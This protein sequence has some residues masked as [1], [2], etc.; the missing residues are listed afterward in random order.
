MEWLNDHRFSRLRAAAEPAPLRAEL[1]SV[2]QL[3][4]HAVKLA[5]AHR[6]ATGR[7]ADRLIPR[8]DENAAILIEAHA[9]VAS[10]VA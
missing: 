9:L 2:D 4:R 6:L 10:A 5:G 7:A 3:A 8:L 1:F